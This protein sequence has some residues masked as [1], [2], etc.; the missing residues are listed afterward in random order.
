MTARN[1]SVRNQLVLAA[2][3]SLVFFISLGGAHLWDVDEAMK[4]GAPILHSTIFTD[5][6]EPKPKKASAAPGAFWFL[7]KKNPL[8]GS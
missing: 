5:G 7:R 3:A 4:P 6:V 2:V 1:S 8:D